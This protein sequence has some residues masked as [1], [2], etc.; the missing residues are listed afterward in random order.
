MY[1]TIWRVAPEKIRV[2]KYQGKC[3]QRSGR[4]INKDNIENSVLSDPYASSEK[5]QSKCGARVSTRGWIKSTRRW[6]GRDRLDF[7]STTGIGPPWVFPM[8]GLFVYLLVKVTWSGLL[9]FF[10]KYRLFVYLLV[11]SHMI[12]P[13][14]FLH[15]DFFFV[16]WSKSHDQA[17]LFFSKSTDFL[18]VSWSKLH[19]QVCLFSS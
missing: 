4:V 5:D 8:Y 13:A 7:G 16:C 3:N 17:R 11:K 6:I 9:I 1:S 19:D 14:Y 10:K 18:F 15:A 12:R 2:I